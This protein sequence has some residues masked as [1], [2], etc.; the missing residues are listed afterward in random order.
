M[1]RPIS[2]N[3]VAYLA[4][5]YEGRPLSES[6]TISLL[7]VLELLTGRPLHLCAQIA[8]DANGNTVERELFAW[9][10]APTCEPRPAVDLLDSDTV[11]AVR[12]CLETMVERARELRFDLDIAIDVAIK[13]LHRWNGG[14]LDLEIRDITSALNVIIESPAFAP[15]KSTLVDSTTFTNVCDDI[16]AAIDSRKLPDDFKQRL[17]Q[18]I[19]EANSISTRERRRCLW[20]AVG[21]EPTPDEANAL[22]RRHVMGHKGFIEPQSSDEEHSLLQD[23]DRTRTLVDEVLLALLHYDG[24]VGAY[25]AGLRPIRRARGK[26]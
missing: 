23:I 10:Q 5:A 2:L 14:Q 17:R 21:F 3:D 16:N 20:Q 6:T 18:R 9:H 25:G 15:A 24:P 22:R 7:S 8:S 11:T 4:I 19:Q 26:A 1:L 12:E 13:Y